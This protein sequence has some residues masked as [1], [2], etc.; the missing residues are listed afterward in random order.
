MQNQLKDVLDRGQ[1]ALGAQLRF[2]SPGIAELFG[3]AGFDWIVIDSEHA[4]QTPVGIQAQIQ[5]I[6]NSSATPIVRLPKVDEE[7]IRLYLDMG[8]MGIMAA[9]VNT[10]DDAESGARACRYPPG[11][12]RG[13]GPHRAAKY[14]LSA[15]EYTEQAN[16]LVT[17][18]GIIETAEAVENIDGILAVDGFDSYVLGSVDLSISLGVPFDFECE[19]FQTAETKVLEAAKRAGK[20]PGIGVYRSPFEPGN[21]KQFADRGYQTLLVGGDEAFLSS[22]CQRMKQLRSDEGI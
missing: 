16:D 18:M 2:G 15:V 5:A 21:M 22:G 9:F 19:I 10:P 11:G 13:W 12:V 3:H 8:A 17:F 20:P 7:Q 14:G 6:G 4:P 1:V